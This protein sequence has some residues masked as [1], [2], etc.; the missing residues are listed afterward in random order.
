MAHY[1]SNRRSTT[2]ELRLK[3]VLPSDSKPHTDITDLLFKSLME[4][5]GV[6][7]L[8]TYP[9]ELRI[10]IAICVAVCAAVGG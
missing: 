9:Q 2:A 10:A 5:L 7:S 6:T 4:K 3:D 1:K 8:K